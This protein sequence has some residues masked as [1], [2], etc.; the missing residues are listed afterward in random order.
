MPTPTKDES[1]K[2]FVDRC[3]P[4]VLKDGT[5]KDQKQ[6]IAICYS[7][8]EESKKKKEKRD[9]GISINSKG[10]SHASSLI[11][12]GKV[13]KTSDWSFSAEDG[14]KLLGDPPNWSEY[15]KWFL[16]VDASADKE[17]KEYYKYPF[18][19]DGKVYRRG[20]IAAKSRA[21]Q[22]GEADISNAA[23]DL[24]KKIDKDKEKNSFEGDEVER[25]THTVK[26]EVR[27]AG[28]GKRSATMSGYAANFNSLSEDLGGFREQLMPGC[29]TDALKTSD[30]RALFNHDPNLILGRNVSGTLRISE[31]EKG[32]RFEV[33]PPETSYAKDL[34][35]SMNRGDINQC[36]FGFKVA[37]GGDSWEKQSNGSYVRSVSKVEKLFDVSPVTYPAYVSTS[38]AVR[39]LENF[40]K[41]IECNESKLATEKAEEQRKFE[42]EQL[43][44]ELKLAELE[45]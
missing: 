4:F 25:R 37:E 33:D 15:S 6:A 40:I 43:E 41:D 13:D 19:K 42:M 11:A 14:N 3:I 38:C 20:I 9:M 26:M 22:Q 27:S 12:E 5:A 36:S 23:D 2:H 39:S 31:D 32:L 24:L 30:V 16:A 35:I 45:L 44:L 18:G 8:F 29:F 21:A 1:E 10:K 34:Q 7:I 17:T 28:Y